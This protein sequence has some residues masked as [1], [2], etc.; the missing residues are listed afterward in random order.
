MDGNPESERDE[1]EENGSHA[2]HDLELDQRNDHNHRADN[3]VD[4]TIKTE[5][6]RRD[7]ELAVHRQKKQR[8]QFS[9]ADQLRNVRDVHEEKRLKKLSNDLVGADQKDDFPFRPIA[10]LLHLAEDDAEEEDLSAEPK[11]LHEHPKNEIGFEAH[12][13][14]E[15]IAQHDRVDFEIAAHVG[16]AQVS[17]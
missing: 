16:S 11:N 12:L 4:D 14:N 9:C 6:F 7:G 1:V 13:A 10:D 5:L 17:R 15:R 8:I 2:R 3:G